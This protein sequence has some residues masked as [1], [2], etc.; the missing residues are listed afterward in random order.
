[1]KTIQLTLGKVALVD[2]EDYDRLNQLRWHANWTGRKWYAHRGNKPICMHHLILDVDEGMEIDHRNGDGLDNRRQNLRVCTTQQ[3]NFNR[4]VNKNNKLGIKGV[5][6]HSQTKKFRAQIMCSGE[7]IYIGGFD[8]AFS[9]DVAYR[10]A[11]KRY[12]GEFAR[13]N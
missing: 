12:F 11:E 10:E 3:N 4:T 7:R 2:D 1:M 8:T 5:S 9:A 13:I 6:W